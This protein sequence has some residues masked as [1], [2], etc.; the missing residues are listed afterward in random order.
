MHGPLRPLGNMRANGVRSLDVTCWQRH[1]PAIMSAD[2]WPDDVPVP[3][4]G[5]RMVCTRCGIVA[6]LSAALAAAAREDGAGE[7]R[8]AG[9]RPASARRLSPKASRYDHFVGAAEQRSPNP[10]WDL[11]RAI[12]KRYQWGGERYGRRH[13]G[14]RSGRAGKTSPIYEERF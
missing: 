2:P 14:A 13:A 11:L 4:F 3:T 5:P 6:R 12:V 9:I 1:H 10:L 7:A 8:L